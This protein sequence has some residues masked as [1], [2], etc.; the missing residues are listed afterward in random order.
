MSI[1]RSASYPLHE[2][3]NNANNTILHLDDVDCYGNE[4]KLSEC[5][6]RGI[7]INNCVVR[8]V[9][10]GVICTSKCYKLQC[11]VVAMYAQY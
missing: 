5:K 4:S 7:G 1:D 11:I 10:A 2:H 6:H 9:E 3:S 8:P